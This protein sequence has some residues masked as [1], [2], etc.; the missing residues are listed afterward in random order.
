MEGRNEKL[1]IIKNFN[2]YINRILNIKNN[3]EIILNILTDMINQTYRRINTASIDDT[4]TNFKYDTY[5]SCM[6]ENEASEAEEEEEEASEVEEE[7]EASESEFDSSKEEDQASEVEEEDEASEVEE[8]DEASEVDSSMDE[9]S[10][11]K[12]NEESDTYNVKTICMGADTFINNEIDIS[13]ILLYKK[14]PSYL[15][16]VTNY[17]QYITTY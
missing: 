12:T 3:N 9:D 6:E 1:K 14:T 15:E 11:S 4:N 13:N 7:D 5:S 16:R 10:E 17:L 8:E 2:K